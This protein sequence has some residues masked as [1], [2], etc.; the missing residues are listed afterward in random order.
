MMELLKKKKTQEMVGAL[1]ILTTA[2][3]LGM[4]IKRLLS[5]KKEEQ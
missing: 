3:I 4:D 5:K 1:V 2:V